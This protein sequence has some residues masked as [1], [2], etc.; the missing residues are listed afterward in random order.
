MFDASNFPKNHASIIPVGKNKKVIGLM[1]DE[2]GGKNIKQFV[3]LRSKLYSYQM[4]EKEEKKCKGVKKG[5][6][7]SHI[8]HQDYL[9]CLQSGKKQMRKMNC[10]RSHQHEIFSETVNKIALSANDDKRVILKDGISTRAH[11]HWEN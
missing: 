1:K 4:D 9:N 6:V 11:G 3:G 10:L 2:A 7:R 5:V 8:C